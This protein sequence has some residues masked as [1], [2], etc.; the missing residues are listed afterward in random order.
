MQK[1]L[2]IQL[3][4]DSKGMAKMRC[5][6]D[7][8][9]DFYQKSLC[10]DEIESQVLAAEKGYYN[11][12]PAKFAQTGQALYHWLDGKDRFLD[13]AL[14][15]CLPADVVV[16]AIETA[17]KL[18]HLPWEV[19]NDGTAFLVQRKNPFIVPVRW[20]NRKSA[21]NDPA[22]RPLRVLFMAASP[23]NVEPV[24]DFEGEEGLI[25]DATQRQPLSLA[26]EE[27]GNLEELE[28]LIASYESGWFDVFHLTGHADRNHE[29]GRFLMETE[30]GEKYE[31]SAKEL[32]NALTRM[33]RLVF[34]SGC[35]TG[36][37]GKGGE[38]PSLAE[39]LIDEGA[40]AVLGW[41]RPVLDRD[42]GLAASYLYG[43]L[44]KGHELART[45]AMTWQKLIDGNARDWH[46]L[47]FYVA[48]NVPGSLVTPLRTTGR[49]LAPPPSAAIEFLDENRE[50]KV[51]SR[52]AFVGRRRA[53]QRCLYALRYEA[54]LAGV[55]VCG[56]GG[57]GKSS[58]AARLCDRVYDEFNVVIRV[59]EIDEPDIVNR[60]GDDLDKDLREHLLDHR[61]ELKLRLRDVFGQIDKPL[62]LVLD[63]FER[64][65]DSRD[66]LIVL[67]ENGL[68]RI[69]SQAKDILEALVFA[70][71]KNPGIRNR[72]IITSRYK[73]GVEEEMFLF[74]EQLDRLPEPDV[75]KKVNRLEAENK[76]LK[77]P[78]KKS[79]SLKIKALYV[80]DGN[81]RLLEWLFAVLK[82]KELDHE[83][84]LERMEAKEIEFRENILAKELLKQQETGLEQMLAFLLVYEIPV[85]KPAV[86]AVCGD[87]ENLKTH[88]ERA[89]ALG[90]LEVAPLPEDGHVYRVPR[91]L[92]PLLKAA[93]PEEMEELYG[94]GARVLYDL[95]W[96]GDVGV[97]EMQ[98][99]EV[100]RLGLMG[101][102]QD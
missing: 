70:I 39:E 41:G 7:N 9:N 80:A 25:L 33:P 17:G 85:P 47:R 90:L 34:L 28:N 92:S 21:K 62:L 93:Q 98:A 61:T 36:E 72:L 60:L 82:Q 26:V 52:Q 48:G 99:L 73:P 68:P 46:L 2:H 94:I 55:L 49:K 45:L 1:T 97:S 27:S 44:S 83:T 32:G 79:D 88:M 43:E 29:G 86:D 5:Y 75:K 6:T 16:L 74:T 35:R 38:I 11:L 12:L 69:S 15:D 102:E 50:I 57:L 40:G 19:I 100:H 63:D 96:K 84:I 13:R 42:A 56:M 66:G 81:P 65:F 71:G 64:N 24:L 53:L 8:P 10:I 77:T 87:I 95:W 67:D 37:S 51:P 59:G 4:E 91:I 101:K 20:K 22:N 14:K 23:L 18:A 30:V 89:A 76:A 54:N 3:K 78:D 31:A 58:L